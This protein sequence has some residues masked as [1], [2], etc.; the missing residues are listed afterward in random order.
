MLRIELTFPVAIAVSKSSISFPQD[1]IIDS[2]MRFL[3]DTF[4][5]TVEKSVPLPGPHPLATEAMTFNSSFMEKG[6]KIQLSKPASSN[7]P[8]SLSLRAVMATTGISFELPM[9]D[10][11]SSSSNLKPSVSGI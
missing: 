7:A 3:S 1:S 6:L 4:A 10:L 9:R 5:S 8:R 11:R 2:R